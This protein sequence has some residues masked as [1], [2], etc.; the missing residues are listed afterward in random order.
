M[1]KNINKTKLLN[2]IINSFSKDLNTKSLKKNLVNKLGKSLGLNYCAIHEFSKKNNN[3][4]VLDEHSEYR[5]LKSVPSN[6]GSNI[7]INLY[8]DITKTIKDNKK[9]IF[10]STAYELIEKCKIKKNKDL[11]KKHL[12][13]FNTKTGIII[14]LLH[15]NELLGFISANYDSKK[16]FTQDELEFFELL[17]SIFANLLH[18]SKL[19]KIEKEALRREYLLRKVV[20]AAKNV[21]D[22]KKVKETI[23]KEVGKAFNADRCYFRSYDKKKQIFEKADVEYRSNKNIISTMDVSPN[24]EGLKYFFDKNKKNQSA[25]IMQDTKK[26][27]EENNLLNTPVS[28]YLLKLNVKSS[29]PF[30][31]WDKE[32]NTTSIVLHYTKKTVYLD[33]DDINFLETLALQAAQTIEQAKVYDKLQDK[34]QQEKITREIVE[35]LRE[36]LDPNKVKKAIVNNI[37]KYFNA[38]RCVLRLLSPDNEPLPINEYSEYRSS[39]NLISMVGNV[40]ISFNKLI[41][42]PKLFTSEDY[43]KSASELPILPKQLIEYLEKYELRSGYIVNI[44]HKGVPIGHLAIHYKEKHK[45]T[46]EKSELLKNIIGQI[47]LALYQSNL[48]QKVNDYNEKAEVY[49]KLISTIRSTLDIKKLKNAF[50]NTI[51]KHFKADRVV[52][53]LYDEKKEAYLPV[54]KSAE[55]LSTPKQPSLVGYDWNNPDIKDFMQPLNKG[56]EVIFSNIDDYI[57]DNKLEKT[58]LLELFEK[59]NIGSSYKIPI[60]YAHKIKGHFRIDFNKKNTVFNNEDLTFLRTLADQ[61]G[62]AIYQA[63]LYEQ[64]RETAEREA[65]LRKT[66]ELIRSTMDVEKIKHYLVYEVSKILNIDRAFFATLNKKTKMFMTPTKDL[67]Y[68][69]DKTYPRLKNIGEY[70]DTEAPYF[71]Y[72]LRKGKTM[73]APDAKKFFAQHNLSDSSEEKFFI[74]YGFISTFVIPVMHENEVFGAF[75]FHYSNPNAFTDKDVEFAKAL[76]D[77]ASIAIYQSELLKKVEKTAKK[78]RILKEIVSEL[79]PS[80]S[81][82]EA[83]QNIIKKLSEIFN[84]NRCLFLEFSKQEPQRATIKHEYLENK[85]LTKTKGSLLPRLSNT[86]FKNLYDNNEILYVPD[87][88]KKFLPSSEFNEFYQSNEIKSFISL[89]IIKETKEKHIF[90]GL[91]ILCS[92]T[93]GHWD[94]EDIELLESIGDTVVSTTGEIIKAKEIEELR[95][96]FILTLAHDLQVPLVGEQKALEFLRL[97]TSANEEMQDLA[98]IINELII[99]NKHVIIMLK[100]LLDNYYYESGQKVLTKELCNIGDIIYQTSNSLQKNAASKKIEI[101][102]NLQKNLPLTILDINEIRKVIT[103]LIDNAITYNHQGGKI[104]INCTADKKNINVSI[105]DNGPGIPKSTREI[106][107]KRYAMALALERRIGS[108]L[109]LYLSKQIIEAHNGYIDYESEEGK[110]TNFYFTI[111]I[112]KE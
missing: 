93:K 103:N 63:E 48:Y 66:A 65:S 11:L 82:D 73:L 91:I 13:L 31:I 70:M 71:A 34:I 98:E 3:I 12:D 41:P 17:A 25:F 40:P 99:S 18:Q 68:L 30:P 90:M 43:Q 75:S 107:F 108:G 24:T 20:E 44:K 32:D 92:S 87:T 28:D 1:N 42:L 45:T 104:E 76:V 10:Y 14:P 64:E 72:N 106:L 58:K 96:T 95:N 69:A 85:D 112:H 110:G 86:S 26:H 89:P 29:Y 59:L 60:M 39:K 77:Q 79:K 4:L 38:D 57:K 53:N 81:L 50:V 111:P 22:L 19:Y 33:D 51:G 100:K 80:H 6:A 67:E 109:S 61:A 8:K 78:E 83:Y 47:S 49:K 15:S 105:Q 23:V 97:R 7:A 21:P 74:N 56:K 46:D 2:E 5:K 62:V 9:I 35:L 16:T 88:E 101:S 84:A 52:I 27:I 54:D 94:E 102:L 36:D 55:F 37:G